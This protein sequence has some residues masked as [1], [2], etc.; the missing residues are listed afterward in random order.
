MNIKTFDPDWWQ[1][2]CNDI[3]QNDP[4]MKNLIEKY[5]LGLA[6]APS[7]ANA[8]KEAI[9]KVLNGSFQYKPKTEKF[10]KDFSLNKVSRLYDQILEQVN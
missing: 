10:I 9:I 8:F 4:V 7:D 5:G 2:A 3:S 6:V 1:E